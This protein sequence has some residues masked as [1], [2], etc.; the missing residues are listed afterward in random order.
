MIA[1][2][3]ARPL[4][5]GALWML[6]AWAAQP[7]T[8][9]AADLRIPPPGASERV[10]A[11]KRRGALRVA[12]LDEH[13][14][15]KRNEE[16]EGARFHGPAWTLAQAYADR[17][18]VRIQ[19]VEVEFANKVSILAADGADIT[20]APLLRTPAREAAVDMISYSAAA[21][22]VFG[23]ADN[24]KV[25]RAATLDDLNRSDVTIGVI[26]DT[27]Q[28]AWLQGRLPKA[29]SRAVPGTLADLATDE[30]LSGRADVAPIDK[31]FV[32]GL[33]RRSPGLVTVPKGDACL[34]SRELSI[35]IGMAVSKGQPEFTAW[36]R[37]VAEAVRPK[38][39]AEEARAMKTGG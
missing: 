14:W 2:R 39:E 13:P 1:S 15:L 10:D 4:I 29:K 12:V 19:T 18:G 35:P 26:R 28:G 7:A 34:A 11:I 38:V 24:P 37:A 9:V 32:A 20:I 22:C 3:T 17:L 33:A 21:H 5:L 25:A 31:F 30:V 36:L 8:A 27:P 16:G 23:R 6:T